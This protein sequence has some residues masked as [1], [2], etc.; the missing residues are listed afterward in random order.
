M[1]P[2]GLSYGCNLGC[3]ETRLNSTGIFC[4]NNESGIPLEEASAEEHHDVKAF[5]EMYQAQTQAAT[6]DLL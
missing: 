5:L 6:V 1:T 3:N 4:V 2:T